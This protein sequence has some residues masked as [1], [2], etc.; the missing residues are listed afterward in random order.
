MIMLSGKLRKVGIMSN[1]SILIALTF[2]AIILTL[3]DFRLG[4]A[5]RFSNPFVIL[6]AVASWAGVSTAVWGFLT[7][8]WYWTVLAI[9]AGY[10][11]SY[12]VIGGSQLSHERRML[13]LLSPVLDILLLITVAYLWIWRWPF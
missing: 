8:P 12:G 13:A 9:V 1:Q 3:F 7:V 6:N 10:A 2:G 5:S 4:V 11:L